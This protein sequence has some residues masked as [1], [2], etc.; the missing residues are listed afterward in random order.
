MSDEKVYLD[1]SQDYLDSIKEFKSSASDLVKEYEGIKIG[2]DQ[3]LVRVHKFMPKVQGSKILMPDSQ[4]NFVKSHEVVHSVLGPCALILKSYE[5]ADFK[6]G[7]LVVLS[8]NKIR[9]YVDNPEWQL[10]EHAMEAKNVEAIEPE[11]KRKKIPFLE[12]VWNDY[13]FVRP[14]KYKPEP[15]DRLTYLLQS[16]EIKAAWEF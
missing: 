8:V 14:W 13:M 9:G 3:Y 1:Y 7:D 15:E 11:D 12:A 16:Y 4:G 2:R 6:E 5:G 10:Y